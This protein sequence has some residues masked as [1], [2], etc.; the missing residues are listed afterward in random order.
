MLSLTPIA[1]YHGPNPFSDESILVGRL[2]CTDAEWRPYA[3]A[4]DRLAAAY[5]DWYVAQDLRALPA[6]M[7]LGHFITD[8]C[9]QALT[10]VRGYVEAKGC[11]R[12]AGRSDLLLWIGWHDAGVALETLRTAI[13]LLD[14][15]LLDRRSPSRLSGADRHG[16]GPAEGDPLYPGLEPAKVLAV[17]RRRKEPGSL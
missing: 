14:M 12:E 7:R 15:A 3:D 2:I 9:L 10:F 6:D 11:K 17:W 1:L 5:S 4:I 16:G 8:W 13:K